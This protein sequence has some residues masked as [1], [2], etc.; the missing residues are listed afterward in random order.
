MGHVN[1]PMIF[2]TLSVV[3]VMQHKVVTSVKVGDKP[4]GV[5]YRAK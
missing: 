4:N 2:G 1:A 5:V 3:D